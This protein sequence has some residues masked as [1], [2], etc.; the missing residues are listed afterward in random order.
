MTARQVRLA[1]HQDSEVRAGLTRVREEL[2]IAVDFPA[3]VRAEAEEAARLTFPQDRYVDA[4]DVPFVTID[5]PESTD[6]DQAVH[7]Q[8]AAMGGFRVRYAIADVAAFV[9]PGA[10]IDRESRARGMTL[11]APDERVLLHPAV[12]SEGAASLLPGQV[13]PAAL[14]DLRVDGDGAVTNVHVQRALVRSRAKLSY[15]E[16]QAALDAGTADDV[17]TGLREVGLRRQEQEQL[18]GGVDR[19]CPSRSWRLP[20]MAGG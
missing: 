6:L 19:R 20:T 4:T 16:V 9:V 14:W 1:A 8:R 18:R 13:R 10:A 17:V 12:L 5:P 15:Q 3:Q 2:G 11:Y 7:V